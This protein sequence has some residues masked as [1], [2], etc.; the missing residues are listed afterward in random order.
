MHFLLLD[1][2]KENLLLGYF[3]E[4]IKKMAT[5]LDDVDY[6]LYEVNK[7]IILDIQNFLIKNQVDSKFIKPYVN[8]EFAK[9]LTQN[10]I[11]K[12]NYSIREY[13]MFNDLLAPVFNIKINFE[14]K[15][16]LLY[17][18]MEYKNS[19][20]ILE[21][22][23]NLNKG[24]DSSNILIPKLTLKPTL[25]TLLIDSIKETIAEEKNMEL[26]NI[27]EIEYYNNNFF[28]NVLAE[29]ILKANHYYKTEYIEKFLHNNFKD[30]IKKDYTKEL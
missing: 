27:K 25:Q 29:F 20:E 12:L 5:V 4:E 3:G 18:I 7:G 23:D 6:C 24:L 16:Y 21:K 19:K 15:F 17:D 26:I 10:N 1:S 8:Y 14:D 28:P 9:R 11:D 13:S 30:L 22:I 2:K